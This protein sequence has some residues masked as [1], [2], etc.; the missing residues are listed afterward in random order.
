[1][2]HDQYYGQLVPNYHQRFSARPGITGL[3]QV[4]GLRG[5]IPDVSHMH[6]RVARDLEYIENWSA[7][8]DVRILFLTVVSAPFHSTAY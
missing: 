5:E 4:T 3:A 1:V 2:A 6:A 7:A 8:M